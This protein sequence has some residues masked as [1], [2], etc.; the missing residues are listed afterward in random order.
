MT[1]LIVRA[2]VVVLLVA[3]TRSGMAQSLDDMAKRV[4][5]D[6]AAAEGAAND[7]EATRSSNAAAWSGEP[8]FA[9]RK[10]TADARLAEARLRLQTGRTMR[11]P[12]ELTRA[13]ALATR[14]IQEYQ[15]LARDIG[16]W[17]RPARP[18]PP[19]VVPEPE[20]TPAP[21]TPALP[22]PREEPTRPAPMPEPEPLPPARPPAELH[23]AATAYL[24]GDYETA[25]GL[26]D[27][28]DSMDGRTMAHALLLRS[29]ARYALYFFGGEKDASL[30]KAA[31][32]DAALCR[33]QDAS[34]V[35]TERIFSPRFRAFFVK[36]GAASSS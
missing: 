28:I 33:R 10:A 3:L 24:K 7:V 25:V 8:K 23:A 29:A 2:L 26:L 34:V 11:D 13:S 19:V 35:P 16:R 20:P 36:A 17:V 4:A 1:R 18:V 22:S 30:L 14:S 21:D 15:S 6:I 12:L 31:G 5:A 27:A 32:E 9:E